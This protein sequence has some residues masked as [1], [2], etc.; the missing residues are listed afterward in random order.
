MVSGRLWS[1][2]YVR[3]PGRDCSTFDVRPSFACASRVLRPS[4][5]SA[6]FSFLSTYDSPS[7][8][9]S[10]HTV[11]GTCTTP[12][13]TSTTSRSIPKQEFIE[14]GYLNPLISQYHTAFAY[15]HVLPNRP[16]NRTTQIPLLFTV[17]PQQII[18]S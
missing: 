17:R 8:R 18:P 13:C 12:F 11:P 16:L 2:K 3:S 7:S 4:F 15:L 5:P 14:I 10:Y 6:L 9:V 1:R